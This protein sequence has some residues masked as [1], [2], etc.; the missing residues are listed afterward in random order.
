MTN[1]R[2]EFNAETGELQ[3]VGLVTESSTAESV[4]HRWHPESI[5]WRTFAGSIE[6]AEDEYFR[7]AD[8]KEYW[9]KVDRVVNN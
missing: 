6:R 8:D 1:A 2:I 9:G 3:F 7:Y 5:E 4:I